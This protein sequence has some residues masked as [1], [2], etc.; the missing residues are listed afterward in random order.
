MDSG[1]DD[2]TCLNGMKHWLEAIAHGRGPAIILSTDSEAATSPPEAAP[3]P[4]LDTTWGTGQSRS[5][6]LVSPRVANQ[7]V[8]DL[9]RSISLNPLI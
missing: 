9:R 2:P 4:V 5:G 6:A 8:V 7:N 1:V 3:S